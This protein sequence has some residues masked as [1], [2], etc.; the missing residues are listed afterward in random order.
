MNKISKKLFKS[1]ILGIIMAIVFV[2]SYVFAS[3]QLTTNFQVNTNLPLDSRT[4]VADIPAR[5][6]I[7]AGQRYE[8]LIVYVV[9]TATNYQLQGGVLD[10][11]WTII[12]G[13]GLATNIAGGS[14]GQILYQSAVDITSKLSNGSFG[15]VLTSN[16]TTLPPS[17]ET[18]SGAAPPITIVGPNNLF[19]TG[20]TGT[21]AG[22]LIATYS[23]FFGENA[24]NAATNASFS[25]FF[26]ENAGN[27]ATSAS[28]SNFFGENAGNT[29]T[30]ASYS[31][32]LGAGAGSSA[33]S[34]HD[35]NFLGSGAGST[36]TSA[37]F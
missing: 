35:S 29:A 21:G 1:S 24:G 10:S 19:S 12:A 20:L 33:T 22:V 2:A 14:G 4:V 28:R 6:A 7:L 5:N 16:G 17:W 27:A 37:S 26:G 31:N 36:A 34:A 15:Q 8:G 13:G 25:N 18:I 32:F 11:N 3:I 30:G 9:S 23:N